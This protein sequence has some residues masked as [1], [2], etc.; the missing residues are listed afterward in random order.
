MNGPSTPLVL[1]ALPDPDVAR[2]CGRWL[3]D[4]GLAALLAH[5]GHEALREIRSSRPRVAVVD[6]ALAGLYGFEILTCIAREPALRSIRTILVTAAH[7]PDRYRR[8]AESLYG[9]EISL[10]R[11]SLPEGLGDALERLGIPTCTALPSSAPLPAQAAIDPAIRT[12]ERLARVFA[13]DLLMDH[14][15]LLDRARSEAE[16]MSAIRADL[17]RGREALRR[18]VPEVATTQRDFVSDAVRCAVAERI[19][20]RRRGTDPR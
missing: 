8:P 5:D 10:D 20:A 13:S 19:T 3:G 15:A 17:D 7:R 18:R 16:V 6:A 4:H 11:S 9:A 2:T 14:G 12:A 1:V